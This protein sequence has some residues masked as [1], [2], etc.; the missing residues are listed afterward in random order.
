LD[1]ADASGIQPSVLASQLVQTVREKIAEKP[2]LLPLLDQL[3]EVAKSPQPN[4]KLLTI[5]AAHAAPKPKSAALIAPPPEVSAPVEELERQTR[6][7]S[8]LSP[9]KSPETASRRASNRAPASLE[10]RAA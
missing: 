9:P 2:Q 1:E 3:L 7:P 10:A 5:L 8:P 6:S 4:I